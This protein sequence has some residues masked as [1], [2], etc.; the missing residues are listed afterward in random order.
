MSVNIYVG[1]LSLSVT[2]GDLERL[3]AEDGGVSS[4]RVIVDRDSGA[5]R[6]F[7]FVEMESDAAARAAIDAMNDTEVEG[8]RLQ[9]NEARERQTRGDV[10]SRFVPCP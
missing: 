6:G 1:N 7:G 2:S 3:F 8:R 10:S 5:S 9:V 4:A